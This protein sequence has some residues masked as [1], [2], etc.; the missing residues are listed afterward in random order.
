MRA[1]EISPARACASVFSY[2]AFQ[3]SGAIAMSRP[4]LNVAAQFS[5]LQPGICPCPFQSPMTKPSKPMRPFSTSVSRL[6]L[7]CIFTPC[8]LENEAITVIAPASIAAG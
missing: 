2:S 8:Q 6:R 1:I 5:L 7:P 3:L 4:A